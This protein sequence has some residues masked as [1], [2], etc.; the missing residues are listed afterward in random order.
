MFEN[1]ISG[2]KFEKQQTDKELY[3][4]KKQFYEMVSKSLENSVRHAPTVIRVLRLL[5]S[6]QKKREHKVKLREKELAQEKTFLPVLEPITGKPMRARFVGAGFN[7]A[8]VPCV[9][10]TPAI[11]AWWETMMY[12]S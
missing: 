3:Q 4:L 12:I 1:Q 6:R 10:R 8:T 7:V 5:Y 2:Y 9:P 11:R